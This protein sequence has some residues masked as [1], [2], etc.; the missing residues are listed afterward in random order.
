MKN[1]FKIVMA[2]LFSVNVQSQII[3]IDPGHGYGATTSDNPDGRT[4]I[5]IETSLEVGLRT[6]T[7]I[8]NSCTWTVHM[9]RTTNLNSWVSVTQRGQ[10]A[11]NWNA[12]RLLSIHCNA[13]GGTGTETFYCTQDDTNTPPDIAFAQKIQTDMVAGGSWNNRRCV[14]DNSFLAYHLG[15]LRYSAAT[16]CLNE[17][18]FVD[19]ATDSAKLTSSSWRDAFAL[20]YFNALKSNLNLTCAASPA[21]GA[22]SLTVTP[23]CST[24]ATPR[25]KLTWTPSA[26]ATAYNVYRNGVLYASNVTNTTYTNTAVTSGTSYSYYVVAKNATA[27]ETSNANGTQT[28]VAL[29]CAVPGSF[30]LTATPQCNGTT[31]QV[32]LSWTT[33]AN[34]TSYDVYRDNVVYAANITGTTYLNTAVVAGTTYNY[35]VKAK[36]TTATQTTNS[37]GT[38]TVIASNCNP[39]P[40]AF[41]ITVTPECSGTGT[42]RNKLTWTAS[43]NATSYNVYRNGVLYA[44]SLTGTTYTNTA[45]TSGTTYSYYVVAKNATTTQ[46]NNSNGTQTVVAL[47]CAAPGAFT[48]SATAECNGTTSRVNLSWTAAAN[49]TSYDIYRNGSLYAADVTGTQFLNT[50]VTVGTSYTYAMVAKNNIGTVAN[51]NGTLSATAIQCAPGAFTASA[52]PTCSGTTSAINVTW[53][54]AVNA[55]SYDIYRNGNLYASDVTGTSFLNTYLITAGTTYTYEVKAKNSAGSLNNSNGILSVTATNCATAKISEEN[56]VKEPISITFYPNPTDGILNLDINKNEI[57]NSYYAVMDSNGRILKEAN[58]EKERTINLS[59]F[60]A[61][62]YFIRVVVDGQEFVK[63]I[64]KK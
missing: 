42:P 56:E 39:I 10:M 46:T 58:L 9:T 64:V 24:T 13:G 3:V 23:E 26:N 43:A 21:P 32:A 28:V 5:E 52:T 27:T 22:F 38:L 37:N 1:I 53:T 48:I 35:S 36:N 30:T 14:E 61:A 49:A 41:T 8:Q 62:T 57:Q 29:N 31:S 16:G 20:S 2:V 50:F 15:V 59:Q 34:A 4:A 51:S 55:T 44:S 60:P 12:D 40:G 33:S 18:G 54:A 6:R 11:N 47:N 25:N 17:I 19:S 63:Q 45:V 7:L